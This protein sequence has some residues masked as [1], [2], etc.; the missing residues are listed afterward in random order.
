[1]GAGRSYE[2]AFKFGCNTIDLEGTSESSTPVLKARKTQKKA[3]SIDTS[4]HSPS[5][6]KIL[7]LPANP[8]NTERLRLD[9]EVREIQ[10]GLQ[11]SKNRDKFEIIAGW[12]VRTNDLRRALLDY[13]PQIVHF[14]GYGN[15]SHG[16][17]LENNSGQLQLVNKDSLASLFSLFQG[18]IKCVFLNACYNEAQSGAIAQHVDYVIGTNQTISDRAATEFAVGFYDALAAGRSI[19]DAYKFGCVAIQLAGIPG[20]SIP[21]LKKRSR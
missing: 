15:D 19:E 3:N 17:A 6:M 7:I 11:R 13:E 5:R 12:G 4:F 8:K 18:K 20:S 9:E 1:L 21:V 16:L 2:D 14:C 10:A